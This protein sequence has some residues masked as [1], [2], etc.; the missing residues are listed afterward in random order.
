M[1]DKYSV[2]ATASRTHRLENVSV[3]RCLPREPSSRAVRVRSSSIPLRVIVYSRHNLS[4]PFPVSLPSESS[5]DDW[6][7]TNWIC[8]DHVIW[9][10]L[11]EL[12]LFFFRRYFGY[13]SVLCSP[14][15]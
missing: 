3:P 2:R 4:M 7:W 11:F 8:M 12:F 1:A 13:L 5:D 10:A 6:W 9:T 15:N 14:L